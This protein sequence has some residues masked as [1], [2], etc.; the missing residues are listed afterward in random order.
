MSLLL[1]FKDFISD[2]NSNDLLTC[3]NYSILLRPI[4]IGLVNVLNSLDKSS[5]EYMCKQ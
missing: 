2:I 3:G 1:K 5:S 4:S